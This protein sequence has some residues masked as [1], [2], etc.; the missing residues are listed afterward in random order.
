MKPSGN[1]IS[2]LSDDLQILHIE[3][4]D[5]HIE[6][7]SSLSSDEEEFEYQ[8]YVFPPPSSS[9]NLKASHVVHLNPTSHYAQLQG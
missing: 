5:N 3:G 6:S 1:T 8:P 2:E 9:L 4:E 7:T